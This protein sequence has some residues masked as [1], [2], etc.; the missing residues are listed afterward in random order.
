M[1]P[2]PCCTS[3]SCQIDLLVFIWFLFS[4]HTSVL[5]AFNGMRLTS[6]RI[7]PR[8]LTAWAQFLCRN[9]EP[10]LGQETSQ[11]QQLQWTTRISRWC[12]VSKP[13]PCCTTRINYRSHPWTMGQ[14]A[15]PSWGTWKMGKGSFLQ[16]YSPKQLLAIPAHI[17]PTWHL[18][19]AHL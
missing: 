8:M 14:Q 16:L 10:F 3:E 5:W 19:W 12:F 7:F 6:K 9:Q 18:C 17:Y 1:A 2:L 4:K 13:F 15:F 11:L